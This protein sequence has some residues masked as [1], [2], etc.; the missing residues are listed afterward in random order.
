MTTSY[1]SA[2]MND[3]LRAYRAR[4]REFIHRDFVPQQDR[5]REQQHPG[6]ESWAAAGAAGLL[7]GDVPGEYGGGGGTFAH[8]AVVV[9]ELAQA[10]V[11]FAA[12]IQ[13]VVAQY[14][15]A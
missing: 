6:A 14:I 3:A 12:L 1:Q 7:L 4:V 8:T 5:W 2:W 15:L 9:E 11:P 10:G 13:N